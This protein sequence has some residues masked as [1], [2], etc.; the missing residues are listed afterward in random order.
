MEDIAFKNYMHEI[1]LLNQNACYM[2]SFVIPQNIYKIYTKV[3]EMPFGT[4]NQSWVATACCK[5]TGEEVIIKSVPKCASSLREI[6]AQRF[7]YEIAPE[8]VLPWFNIFSFEDSLFIIMPY[9]N[10]G[11]LLSYIDILTESQTRTIMLQICTVVAK[12]HSFG[13]VHRDIKVKNI[14]FNI[15]F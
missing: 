11:D 14:C 15:L 1:N 13:L 3:K 2:P 10:G 8:N 9:I 12:L 4:V 7:A 6:L 5:Q